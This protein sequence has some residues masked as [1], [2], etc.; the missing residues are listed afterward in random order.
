MKIE[1]SPYPNAKMLKNKWV[2]VLSIGNFNTIKERHKR[3]DYSYDTE[4]EFID[5]YIVANNILK[6]NKKY[7]LITPSILDHL[8]SNQKSALELIC[9]NGNYQQEFIDEVEKLLDGNFNIQE[10]FEQ[11]FGECIYDDL[12]QEYFTN[13]CE[14]KDMYHYDSNGDKFKITIKE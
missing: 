10:L 6:F 2:L 13:I 4:E 7:N 5:A 9:K 3:A 8:M 14:I 1:L 11:T 12:T